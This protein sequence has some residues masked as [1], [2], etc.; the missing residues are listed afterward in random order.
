M[1]APLSGNTVLVLGA[2]SQVGIF[3][4]P[5]LAAAGARVIAVSRGGR[6]QGWPELPGV[7]WTGAGPG[8]VPGV[9]AID[10]LLSAGPL[11]LASAWLAARREIGRIAATSTTSVTVKADSADSAERRAMAEIRAAEES[12]AQA[13]A[14]RGAPLV[15][16]RPT[17][18][19]GC[20]LD[21]N[22]T[23][24]ARFIERFGFCPVARGAAGRRQPLHAAD[25]AEALVRGL[26]RWNEGQLAAPLCGGETVVYPEMAGRVCEALGRPRRLLPL[27]SGPFAA[28]AGAVG[29][30]TGSGLNA[31]MVRRQARD[32]VFDDREA[33][34]ALGV[35]PRGFR[36]RRSDF[37]PPSEAVMAD[38]AR[39]A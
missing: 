36:P 7:T 16:L 26:S 35:A 10:A 25:L 15:L 31:E 29:V 20:G 14:G 6:P 23:S 2:S 21:R 17:L 8:E 30:L 18:V 11:A 27:P 12:L 28:A 32:L 24:L 3:A 37:P 22:V 34:D 9:T 33:R 5:A 39:P 1:A 13:C 19:W 38:L 4:V